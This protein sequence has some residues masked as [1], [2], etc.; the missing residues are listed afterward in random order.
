M[1]MLKESRATYESAVK[2]FENT[3]SI[4]ATKIGELERASVSSGLTESGQNFDKTLKVLIDILREEIEMISI[5]TKSTKTV[6]KNVENISEDH[7]W[8]FQ[9]VKTIFMNEFD[10]L[11]NTTNTF[12]A[13]PKDIMKLN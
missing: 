3:N 5:W 2:T 4:L 1:E 12:L 7:L 6:R 8:Q 13:Q 11:E 10:D 9:S